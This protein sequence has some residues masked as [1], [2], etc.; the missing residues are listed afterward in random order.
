M[1]EEVEELTVLEVANAKYVEKRS[2][3][4]R[5]LGNLRGVGRSLFL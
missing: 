4:G 1:A 2:P 3:S 5:L